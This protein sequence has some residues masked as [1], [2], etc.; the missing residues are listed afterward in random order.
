MV[1][2]SAGVWCFLVTSDSAF[3]STENTRI[4]RI[5]TVLLFITVVAGRPLDSCIL[6]L[7]SFQLLPILYARQVKSTSDIFLVGSVVVTVT[8]TEA[9]GV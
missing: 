1:D 9:C 3:A 2:N 5:V 6:Y 7:R 4:V 8:P